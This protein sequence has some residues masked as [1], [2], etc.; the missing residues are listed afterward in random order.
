MEK[1][2]LENLTASERPVSVWLGTGNR[3]W[4]NRKEE[5]VNLTSSEIPVSVYSKNI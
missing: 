5:L 3:K 2:E 1:Q 4:E